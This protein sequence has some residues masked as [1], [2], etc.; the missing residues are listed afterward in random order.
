MYPSLSTL[1]GARFVVA[2]Y[3]WGGLLA[4]T[5]GVL[6]AAPAQAAAP[7]AP[8]THRVA[9]V[10]AGS[11]YVLSGTATLRLT[12]DTDDS[13]PRWSPDAARIAFGHAGRL[14]VMNSDGTG[15]HAVASGPA[16]GAAWSPDGSRLAF[17]APG[18]TG[19]EGVFAVAAAGGT[20]QALFPVVCRG[21]AAPRQPGA[22][23][24]QGWDQGHVPFLPLNVSFC[25]N[26]PHIVLSAQRACQAGYPRGPVAA[27]CPLPSGSLVW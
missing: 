7:A 1:R 9:F 15:R 10:R 4:A 24:L 21:R 6:I 18:C 17:A 25:N 3:V 8:A 26:R 19:I 22:K 2:R 11:I 5:L 23:R 14:W 13:R 20:P 16:G 27:S 12:R